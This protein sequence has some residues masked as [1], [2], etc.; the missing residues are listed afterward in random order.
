ME[1]DATAPHHPKPRDEWMKLIVK[2]SQSASEEEK[3]KCLQDVMDQIDQILVHPGYGTFLNGAMPALLSYLKQTEPE[4]IQ[5]TPKHQCRKLL[6]EII[7]RLPSNEPLRPHVRDIVSAMFKN[8][9][10]DNEENVVNCLRVIIELHKQFR[11]AI[12]TETSQFLN[13]VKTVFRE[14]QNKLDKI[15][16]QKPIFKV[17]E[18]SEQALR[19]LLEEIF[20]VTP[21][22][23]VLNVGEKPKN[24][25]PKAANSLKVLQELPIIVVL[26][27][28]IY[29]QSVQNEV[30]EYI[31]VII[32]TISLHPTEAQRYAD[33][34][35]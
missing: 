35:L 20:V 15:F 16:E 3:L 14:I 7:H 31:P 24:L 21:I 29:K 2:F 13:F 17:K 4:F 25:I 23:N 5:E 10:I 27:Y 9:E 22:H 28:Q 8:V 1:F 30:A 34:F 6:I 18:T 12:T 33:R 11:P 32:T 19:P 26:M